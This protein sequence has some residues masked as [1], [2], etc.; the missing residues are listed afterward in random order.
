MQAALEIGIEEGINPHLEHPESSKPSRC[1]D[2]K[3]MR[4]ISRRSVRGLT[5][6]ETAHPGQAL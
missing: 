1:R 2:L 3:P 6:T 5:L 4:L